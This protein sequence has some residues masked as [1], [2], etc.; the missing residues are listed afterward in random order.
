MVF[1]GFPSE[2][3]GEGKL[4]EAASCVFPEQGKKG[5]DDDEGKT[6]T[7]LGVTT[8]ATLRVIRN[9]SRSILRKATPFL[10]IRLIS[11]RISL[12]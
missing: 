7:E 9:P 3:G 1:A 11:E 4:L 10:F 6:V 8:S 12:R 5:E 2:E